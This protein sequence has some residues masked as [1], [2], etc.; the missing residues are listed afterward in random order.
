M[1]PLSTNEKFTQ[2]LN[3]IQGFEISEEMSRKN[4]YNSLHEKECDFFSL[5][6][7]GHLKVETNPYL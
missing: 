1:V 3:L 2:L 4:I 7:D 6:A 5:H